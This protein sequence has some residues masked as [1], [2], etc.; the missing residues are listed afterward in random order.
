MTQRPFTALFLGVALALGSAA[1]IKK[2]EEPSELAINL[3]TGIRNFVSLGD[4]EADV[5]RLTQ[6]TFVQEEITPEA[7]N[8]PLS[9]IKVTHL[10]Y[11]KDIGTKLYFRDGRVVLMEIQEPFKGAISGKTIKLFQFEAR[12][13]TKSWGEVL[14]REFG[15]S[16][17]RGSGGRF[18]AEALYYS[19]GDISYNRMGPNEIALYTDSTITGYRQRTFGREIRLFK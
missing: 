16:T 14:E 8:A 18:G 3:Y 12:A 9:E 2:A 4:T 1:C 7:A 6:Y 17:A 19:W 11:Y 15:P 10:F 13:D 5:K